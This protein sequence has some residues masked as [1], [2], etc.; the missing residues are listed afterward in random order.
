[1]MGHYDYYGITGNSKSLAL[2]YYEIHGIWYKWLARRFFEIPVHF[3]K[4][5]Y[6]SE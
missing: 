1:M 6:Y 5:C 2:Y 3:S 4:A